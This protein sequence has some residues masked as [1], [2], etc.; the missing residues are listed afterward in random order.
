MNQD[1]LMDLFR[2]ATEAAGNHQYWPALEH[3]TQLLT[4]IPPNAAE[5]S[6]QEKRL[7]ALRERGRLLGLL[8]EQ[9]AALSAYVQYYREANDTLR[10]IDALIKIGDRSRGIGRYPQSLDAYHEALSLAEKEDDAVSR[11]R[12]LAGIGGTNLM[13][14]RREEAIIYLRE[15]TTLFEESGNAA[16][17]IRTLNRMGVAYAYGGQMDQAITA[18]TD[19]LNLSRKIGQQDT[20]VAAL[21]NLGECHQSLFDYEQ[22]LI[23][24]EEGLRLVEKSQLRLFEADICR[25]L[26]L[27]LYQLGRT[28]E[29]FD[30]LNRA[31][32]VSQE[33]KHSDTFAHTLYALS[34]TEIERENLD[35][36]QKHALHLKELAAQNDARNLLAFADYALGLY[37]RKKG[38]SE[39]AEQFWQ[40]T[41]F[42]AHETN[43]RTL[44]WKTHAKLAQT[45]VNPNMARVHRR[46]AAE[47]ILQI[48]EPIADEALRQKFLT[49]PQVRPLLETD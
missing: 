35:T 40:Q 14:G 38:E 39:I 46:I 9:E 16:R 41:L 2:Q 33:T 47:V 44:L 31:L 21:N 48:A 18:F 49:A 7:T 43:N 45:A 24:H 26:G 32:T 28:D 27:D 15:A 12:A 8:G 36:A 13:Q 4:L 34:L 23:F 11:G 1:T 10:H 19:A 22:A 42:Q 6:A 30:F 29:G 5:S 17:Q 3:Y 25:N 20:A 37:H